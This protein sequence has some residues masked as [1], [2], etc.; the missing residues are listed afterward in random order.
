MLC[1]STVPIMFLKI[2]INNLKKILTS[3]FFMRGKMKGST[4]SLKFRP[5][6]AKIFVEKKS[7]EK[8]FLKFFFQFFCRCFLNKRF[9]SRYFG[10]K[11]AIPNMRKESHEL[12]R[13]RSRKG[14]LPTIKSLVAFHTCLNL[15]VWSSSLLS[16]VRSSSLSSL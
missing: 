14:L 16:R 9:T 6:R 15:V 8:I 1:K 7:L 12:L 11:A 4:K 5:Y 3:V 2:Y 13:L 10:K